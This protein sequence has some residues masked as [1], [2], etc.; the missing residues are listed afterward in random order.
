LGLGDPPADL[1]ALMRHGAYLE[2]RFPG[3]TLAFSLPRIH[4]APEGFQVPCPVSDEDLQRMYC[5]LRIAFPAAVLVLS[6]REAAPL[7]DRLARICI[8]QMS[9]GSSTT[10]GGYGQDAETA[11]Q[12]FPVVD[13]R[14]AA[15]VAEGLVA[16]GYR[17]CWSTCE[18]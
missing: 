13:H 1:L 5:A 9:A 16:K 6:T 10:P 18:E 8:T 14:S 11:G 3:C 17:V 2:N 15:E 7:R 4:E 12:Q